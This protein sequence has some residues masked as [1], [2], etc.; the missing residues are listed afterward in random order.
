MSSSTS[1]LMKVSS[2]PSRSTAALS[3][4][5]SGSVRAISRILTISL[6]SR[7]LRGY[8]RKS[9]RRVGK[10]AS[11]RA[12]MSRVFRMFSFRTKRRISMILMRPVPSF[13]LLRALTAS[14]SQLFCTKCSSSFLN[15]DTTASSSGSTKGTLV[16]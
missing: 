2:A 11:V 9:A 6:W 8:S 15:S 3:G 16:R 10:K 4:E 7:L 1:S 14:F 13:G 12:T 5:P